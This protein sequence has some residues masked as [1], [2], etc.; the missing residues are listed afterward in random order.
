MVSAY[1]LALKIVVQLFL[2][3]WYPSNQYTRFSSTFDIDEQTKQIRLFKS[4]ADTDTKKLS[5]CVE[6]FYHCAELF[7]CHHGIK[8]V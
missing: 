8:P 5:Y 6:T 7:S 2:N 4:R 3:K 1:S